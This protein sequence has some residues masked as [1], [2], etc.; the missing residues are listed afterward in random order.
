ML[1]ISW[2]MPL[3]FFQL[4]AFPVRLLSSLKWKWSIG[5]GQDE[6]TQ[7]INTATN[8][9]YN[10]TPLSFSCISRVKEESRASATWPGSRSSW[11]LHTGSPPHSNLPSDLFR[12][13]C[14]FLSTHTGAGHSALWMPLQRLA[15]AVSSALLAMLR[16]GSNLALIK[17]P[18]L[19]S[20]FN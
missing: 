9:S 10:C 6:V 2:L 11:D 12:P 4:F 19:T 3:P 1:E 13:V 7:A 8:H 20:F 14:W 15:Q 17:C 18:S 16:V 5:N